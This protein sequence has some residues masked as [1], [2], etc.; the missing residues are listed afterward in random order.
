MSVDISLVLGSFVAML[1]GFFAIAKVMLNQASKDRQAERVERDA[2]R[3]ERKE[4][5]KA[6][7]D[8][9]RAAGRQ[10]DATVRSADEAEQRNGHLAELVTQNGKVCS[11]ILDKVSQ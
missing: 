8:M 11:E 1:G 9:A 6:I 5:S 4:L 3:Q 7:Q 10:A 2:D